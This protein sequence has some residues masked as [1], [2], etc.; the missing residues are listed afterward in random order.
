MD[1]SITIVT[2]FFDIGRGNWTNEKGY[3]SHL[4]RTTETYLKYFNNLAKINNNMVI[5]TSREFKD[6]IEKA[7]IGKPTT[8][9]T[10]DLKNRFHFFRKK[11]SSIQNDDK[12]KNNLDKKQIKNPEYWSPDYVLVCNLKTYLV[13][14]AINLKLVKTNLVSWV[15]FGYCRTPETIG[16]IKEWK[17]PFDKNRMHFFTIKKGLEVKTIE[18]VFDKMLNNDVFI[19]GGVIVGSKEKWLE[20]YKLVLSCQKLTLKHNIVDDDQGIFIM[21]Y[22][23]RPELIKLNFLGKNKWFHLF[24]KFNISSLNG[25]IGFI[26]SKF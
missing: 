2:A 26:K 14:K 13:S 22:H 17:Y 1:S 4:H 11:I 7:R 8:V 3:D 6:D 24:K 23:K 10:I 19:I 16:K 12:F 25:I 20:F 15:D 5:F 18:S 21:C 9:I